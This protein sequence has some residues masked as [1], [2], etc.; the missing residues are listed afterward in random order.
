MDLDFRVERPVVNTASFHKSPA[1]E[2]N[3]LSSHCG[4]FKCPTLFNFCQNI[5]ELFRFGD[6][7]L[8][9]DISSHF[10]TNNH[11]TF[12]VFLTADPRLT[13]QNTESMEKL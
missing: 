5:P 9:S 10:Q 3:L 12:K 13:P 1:Q 6:L 2:G 7:C 8:C 4:I 11:S